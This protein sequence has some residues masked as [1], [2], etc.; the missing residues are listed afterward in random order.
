[1]NDSAVPGSGNIL[2]AAGITKR[3]GALTV[4]DDVS[5]TVRRGETIC[6]LGPSGAGKSTFL[7][8][9]NM[10]EPIDEGYILLDGDMLGYRSHRGRLREL[11][12]R[13]EARQRQQIGM[14]FQQFNLFPHMSCWPT[15][16]RHR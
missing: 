1:M 4:V 7:R 11:S 12:D 5:L 15:S 10:L 9:L 6:L 3:Y 8:C 16:P 13:A 2:E 14:V